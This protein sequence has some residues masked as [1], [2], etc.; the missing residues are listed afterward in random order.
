MFR[1]SVEIKK[2][3]DEIREFKNERGNGSRE[4]VVRKRKRNQVWK[5]R[6]FDGNKAR[7]LIFAQPKYLK[8]RQS[9]QN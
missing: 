5:R 8:K 3:K 7:K 6:K 1:K 9:K 2:T 4:R